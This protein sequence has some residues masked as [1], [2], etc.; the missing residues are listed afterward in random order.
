MRALCLALCLAAAPAFA[1][2]IALTS[3]VT[4]ATLYPQG[5]TVT[6]EVPFAVPAGAHDLVIADLPR[7]TPLSAVRVALD[8][9]PVTGVTTRDDYVPPRDTTETAALRDARAEVT[10]RETALRDAEAKIEEI[11]LEA[12]SARSR[13]AFLDRIGEGDS[14]AALDPE[15]LRALSQM[16]GEETLA[17]R[18]S[19]LAATRRAAMAERALTDHK[20]ALEAARKA[21]RALVPEAEARAMV[22]VSVTAQTTSEGR[23]TITYT[24][25]D[26]GWQPVYDLYLDRASGALRIDRG[27]LLRQTT[28]ENWQGVALTLSTLRPSAQ[29]A[30]GELWPWLPRIDDPDTI[31]PLADAE[32]GLR[33]LAEPEMANALAAT[34]VADG[35]SVS[36]TAASPVDI[37]TGADHVRI[38]LGTVQTKA[39]VVAEAVPMLDQT[40]FVMATITNDSGEILLPTN[41][42][43]FYLDGRYVGQRG[44]AQIADGDSARLSFGPI[45]GLRLSRVVE[46]R[47]DGDRGLI[48]KSNERAE[49]VRIKV[50]NLTGLDWPVRVL[51]RVP[52]SQQEDLRIEW[53]ATPPPSLQDVEDRR[54]ILGWTFTLPAKASRTIRLDTVLQ[55]PGD[56]VL[57]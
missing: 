3:R 23:L 30:P 49:T 50:E 42:A 40:A 51:D 55:W 6:R 28:G 32:G 37:A 13:L 34:A 39:S 2:D 16:I 27:A 54:G 8:G 35:L 7:D 4:A 11:R 18:Q 44:I 48:R 10:R 47:V 12:E 25:P 41:E 14:M 38:A 19:A 24:I 29:T 17:A 57:Q 5:A 33:S 15:R 52:V 46:D 45:D 31:R 53:E 26:A 43:R 9:L 36:Y 20:T 22:A 56:K 21:L 1:D